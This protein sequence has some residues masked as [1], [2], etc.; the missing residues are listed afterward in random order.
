MKEWCHHLLLKMI[1]GVTHGEIY[2]DIWDCSRVIG[3]L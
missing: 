3:V 1:F 2:R